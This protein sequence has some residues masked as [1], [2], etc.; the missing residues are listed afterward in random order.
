MGA[1]GAHTVQAIISSARRFS[2]KQYHPTE[3]IPGNIGINEIENHA[4]T[5]CAGPN[6]R[7]IELSG[8]RCT[9]SPF[10]AEYQ[11]KPDVQIAKYAT[12]Y[13]SALVW[14]RLTLFIN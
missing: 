1:S 9:V 7:L 6:W 4:D 10:S 14:Q 5:T 2:S 12:T 11:P 8:K 13:A 3:T